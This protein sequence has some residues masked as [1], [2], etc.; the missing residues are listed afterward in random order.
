MLY[1]CAMQT[2]HIEQLG[3]DLSFTMIY[4]KGGRFMMGDDQ[5][6]DEDEKPAHPVSLHDFYIAEFPV[7]QEVWK[8]VMGQENNPSF[9]E[10]DA[11]PVETVSWDACQRFLQQ[12]SK[13]TGKVYRLPTEAEWEYAARGGQE[14]QGYRYAGSNQLDEVGWFRDNADQE[15]KDVGQKQPNELGLYDMSGNVW[16]FCQD[17]YLEEYYKECARAGG[18]QNPK[19][20]DQGDYRVHR[21]G[22][23]N[24]YSQYCRSTFRNSY[25]LEYEVNNLGLRLVISP[26]Q[27]VAPSGLPVSERS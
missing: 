4:V 27:L 7:T 19:G 25:W 18:V 3:N 17:W 23:W 15:S 6:V 11:R 5:G 8:A 2:I 22:S 13:M 20:P 21:G 14:S 26:S 16:E 1:I 24:D 9:F 12:L 10:G